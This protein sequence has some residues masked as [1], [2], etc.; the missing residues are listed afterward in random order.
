M[1][2]CV[3]LLYFSPPLD[4]SSLSPYLIPLSLSL[5]HPLPSAILY[6]SLSVYKSKTYIVLHCSHSLKHKPFFIFHPW[7]TLTPISSH[8]VVSSTTILL[9][10]LHPTTIPMLTT[11]STKMVPTS[12]ITTTTPF[13]TS[14]IFKPLFVLLFLLLLRPLPL[15]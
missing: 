14:T 6:F 12:S 2:C 5:H 1:I 13:S 9:Q 7:Q 11:S 3:S 10:T 15:P 8:Q 4:F